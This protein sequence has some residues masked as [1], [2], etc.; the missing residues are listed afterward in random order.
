MVW[1]YNAF[2]LSGV[3]PLAYL[4]WVF[5]SCWNRALPGIFIVSHITYTCSGARGYLSTGPPCHHQI[6]NIIV[7]MTGMTWLLASHHCQHHTVVSIMSLSA[8]HHWKHHA[9]VTIASFPAPCHCQ[10]HIIVSITLLSAS[11]LHHSIVN[12]TSLSPSC[13]WQHHLIVSI[14]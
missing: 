1:P 4:F 9:F 7:I 14:T 5:V 3:S 10:L 13:H 12:I 8:S 6:Y 2:S 11:H